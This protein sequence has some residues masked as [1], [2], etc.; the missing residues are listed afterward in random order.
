MMVNFKSAPEELKSECKQ[1]VAQM[2]KLASK[3]Q[4]IK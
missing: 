3:I 2:M 4:N 1:V